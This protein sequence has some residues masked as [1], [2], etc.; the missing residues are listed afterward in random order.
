[1][2]IHDTDFV[3]ALLSP[4]KYDPPLLVHADGMQA[5]KIAFERFESIPRR[6]GQI[7]ELSRAIQL[8]QLEKRDSCH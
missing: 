5:G 4:P 6:N 1:M 8:N 3:G 2:V 7:R